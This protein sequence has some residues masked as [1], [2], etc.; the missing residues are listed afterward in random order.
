MNETWLLNLKFG[1][2]VAIRLH[3][4]YSHAVFTEVPWTLALSLFHWYSISIE[5]VNLV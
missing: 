4:K 1:I 5:T 2:Q 3:R